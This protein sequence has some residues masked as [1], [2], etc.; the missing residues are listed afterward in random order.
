MRI[1]I[2]LA[3][4]L[5]SFLNAQINRSATELARENIQIYI[6][7]KLF[8]DHQYKP[9]SYSV[10]KPD[11]DAETVWT[12]NHTFEITT[13]PVVSFIKTTTT[14][15]TKLYK[16]AFYLDRKMEVCKAIGYSK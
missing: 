8:K 3:F 5:P 15:T 16:F 2:I 13:S 4:T 14:S 9:L 12:I 11:A 7:N 6:K 1:I 10:L